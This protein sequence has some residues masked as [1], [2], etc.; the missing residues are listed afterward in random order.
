MC[1]STREPNLKR[2]STGGILEGWRTG[3]HVN[4]DSGRRV[5]SK[6]L[7]ETEGGYNFRDK[8]SRV[9]KWKDR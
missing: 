6:P 9:Q 5:D 4:K 2:A 8:G 3:V 7:K 1:P